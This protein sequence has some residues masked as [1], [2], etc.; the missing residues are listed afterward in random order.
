MSLVEPLSRPVRPRRTATLTGYALFH[1]NLMFSSIEEEQRPA[2]IARCYHPLLDLADAG[3][4]LGIEATGLTL[5]LIED[6]DPEWIARLKRLIVA[7]R[8]EFVGSGYAQAIGPLMPWQA[9]LKN[10]TLGRD[11]YRRLLDVD[12]ALALVNEQAWSGGLV[13]LYREAGYRALVMDWDDCAAHHPEWNRHWRYH[14]QRALGADGSRIDLLWSNT[15]AFQK[16]QRLAHGDIDLDAYVDFVAGHRGPV[17]RVLALYTNDAECFDFRPG[18]F[19]TEEQVTIGE[20]RRVGE[21]LKALAARGVVLALP[22]DALK[23]AQGGNAGNDLVLEAP[24]NPVPVKKQPK[25]NL[26]RWASSGRDD[27]AVNT[28]CHQAFR[29]LGPDSPD[30]DWRTLCRLWSSDFRTHITGKRWTAFRAE[31]D[32]FLARLPA[33][34]P[35]KA[36]RIAATGPTPAIEQDVRHI[37]IETPSL[38]LVLDKRRGLAIAAMGRPNERPLIGGLAHGEIDDIALSAD[39][40]TGNCVFEGPGEPK[41]TDL[42]RCAPL[43]ASGPDG[44]IVVSARIETPLGPIDKA[45]RIAPDAPRVETDLTFRWPHWGKGS[46]RLAHV[47]LKSDAFDLPNLAYAAHNGGRDLERFALWGHAVDLGAAVS[48][49]ISCRAGVGMTEGLLA[50]DDGVNAVRLTADLASAAVIG[51]VEHRTLHGQTFCRMMLSAL[52]MDETRRPDLPSPPRRV[53]YALEIGRVNAC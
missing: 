4:P 19:A 16:L 8:A 46:L 9:V 24:S 28:L 41:V 30:E 31:L 38:R 49:L 44:G 7:G 35:R 5:E 10:L 23:A 34:Q 32:A 20:W 21:G 47:T 17:E 1:L 50:L 43:M 27:L 12:P 11:V 45:L 2:V 36:T 37:L 33:P 3:I 6:I 42:E 53:R 25:Y 13:P 40:Y 51:L 26:T 52:E 22:G 18:R 14:P 39:W 15:I 48:F 29:A